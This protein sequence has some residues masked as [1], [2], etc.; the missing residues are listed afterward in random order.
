MDRSPSKTPP[1]TRSHPFRRSCRRRVSVRPI[2][3][4]RFT[5]ASSVRGD[6]GRAD[7]LSPPR[8]LD[9]ARAETLWVVGTA[10]TAETEG[11]ARRAGTAGLGT[12]AWVTARAVAPGQSVTGIG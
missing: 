7:R 2:G 1:A 8:E 10:G 4:Y 5:A 11:T 6:Q 9:D 12:G 3:L